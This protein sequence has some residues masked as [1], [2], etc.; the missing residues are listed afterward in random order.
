M[1]DIV[2]GLFSDSK[3]AGAAISELKDKGYTD[4][5][6]VVAKDPDS[7]KTTSHS[8]KNNTKSLFI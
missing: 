1:A 8:V 5:I 7:G 2:T 3:Q 4:N 6:S